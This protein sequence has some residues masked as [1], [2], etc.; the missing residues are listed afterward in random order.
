MRNYLVLAIVIIALGS[1]AIFATDKWPHQLETASAVVLYVDNHQLRSVTLESHGNDYPQIKAQPTSILDATA[2][3][4]FDLSSSTIL[5]GRKQSGGLPSIWALTRGSGQVK[6]IYQGASMARLSPDSDRVVVTNGNSNEMY[7]LYRDGVTIARIGVH[8]GSAAFS[9][10][11]KRLAY[12]KLSD[13]TENLDPGNPKKF[14]GITVYDISSG[15]ENLVLPAHD[16]DYGVAS[17]SP[18]GS[19]IYYLGEKEVDS[20]SFS[21]A[22]YSIGSNGVDDRIEID[23]AVSSAPPLNSRTVWFPDKHVAVSEGGGIWGYLFDDH[24]HVVKSLQISEGDNLQA[25]LPGASVAFRINGDKQ[26]WVVL[27]AA[28][29]QKI[30]KTSSKVDLVSIFGN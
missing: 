18:D 12:M 17:W 9:P 26:K 15:E 20:G 22:M 16:Q 11:G 7:V 28:T 8:G 21:S 14:V 24:Y 25:F 1:G 4:I 2:D 6:E 30:L 29:I 13:D 5:F 10:D 27:E 19:R 23:P 3:V